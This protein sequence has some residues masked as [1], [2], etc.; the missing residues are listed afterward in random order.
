MKIHDFIELID[1]QPMDVVFS[2]KLRQL[3]GAEIPTCLQK[4]VSISPEGMFFDGDD[5]LR[6]LAKTE[7]IEASKE[8]QVDFIGLQLIPIFDTGDN[9]FIVFD[10]ESN[11][12]CKFNIVDSIKFKRKKALSEFFC[13]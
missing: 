5:T 3:Y 1:S 12:W 6:L 9:D 8:L 2:E 10:I 13:E 4:V 7:I 11:I